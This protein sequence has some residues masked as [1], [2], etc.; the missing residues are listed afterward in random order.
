MQ[1]VLDV[2]TVD[3]QIVKGSLRLAD[4]LTAVEDPA[5]Q[6]TL[7]R[8]LSLTDGL[9]HFVNRA[10]GSMPAGLVP[11]LVRRLKKRGHDVEIRE[12]PVQAMTPIRPDYLIGTDLREY[13]TSAID[14]ALASRR[15]VLW[16]ATNAGKS[17]VAAAL[18]GKI[19]RE[20]KGTVLVIV[21]TGT[22]LYQTS[23]DI[24]K[25]LGRDVKVEIAGDGHRPGKPDIL[26]GTYQTV[27]QALSSRSKS[28]STIRHFVANCRGI[29]VDEGHHSASPSHVKILR[30]AEKAVF[31][32]GL[33][34]TAKNRDKAI[35]VKADIKAKAHL[36]QMECY[37]GPI[38]AHVSNEDLIELGV[39]AKPTI[40]VV[41]DRDAFGP[42]I[43]TPVPKSAFGGRRRENIY[44]KVFNVAVIGNR[45]LNKT[46]V[47]VA[48]ALLTQSRP[49]F[50]F[51]HSVDHLHALSEIATRLNVPHKV[52]Y[53][54]SP[55]AVRQ[56]ILRRFAKRQDFAIFCSTIFDEGVSIPAIRAVVFAG[57]RKTAREVLQR[58]GRGLRKKDGDNTVAVVDFAMPH[59]PMLN[60]HFKSR[61][62][63]YE[64]EGFKV[65]WLKHATELHTYAF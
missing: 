56:K 32:L 26:V 30:S 41:S 35:N 8:K 46:I 20:A 18:C 16:L 1:Y 44:Q 51:S 48:A 5:K 31:R 33:T 64:G 19:V 37:L 55:I 60:K 11:R 38:L 23:E 65:R 43:R 61:L 34:G 12:Q 9:M 3:A 42:D 49:P 10:D 53:G 6:R 40:H 45:K 27:S 57:A 4:R 28:Y 36:R 24:A 59:S 17:Y 2:G 54:N 21:P 39:S 62:A 29:L 22:L 14:I 50:I 63:S 52:L 7:E 13:Q 47:K 25:L 15:G 58:I